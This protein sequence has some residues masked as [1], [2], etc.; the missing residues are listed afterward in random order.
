M[1][2]LSNA[3]LGEDHF[4]SKSQEFIA[5]AI[6]E[7]LENN[8]SQE[9][10]SGCQKMIGIEG[11]WGSGKSN[12]IKIVEN[13]VKK[14]HSGKFHFFTYDVWG[15]QEDLQRKA[16][17]NELVDFLLKKEILC[18]KEDEAEAD[19]WKEKVKR[20]TGTITETTQFQLPRVSWGVFFCALI[21]ITTPVCEG[22]ANLNYFENH[23]LWRLLIA[24]VP[25][26]LLFVLYFG[27][28]NKKCH[29][30]KKRPF[31]PTKKMFK[32]TFAE[33][34]CVYEDR[35]I[36]STNRE[37][38]SEINPSV[39]DFRNLLK[40]ISNALQDRNK[41]LVIIFDNMDRLP[42]EKIENLW[43]SI[44][45]FFAENNGNR[46][47]SCI[48]S[49]DRSHIREA[50]PSNNESDKSYGDGYIDKTFDIVYRVAPPVL[51]DW[52]NFFKC[53][54]LKVF[55]SIN[56]QEEYEYVVQA[57]DL[58]SDKQGFTPRSIIK[59][60]NEIALL[61]K[62]FPNIP[63]RYKAIFTLKK[64]FLIENFPDKSCLK[65]L[66]PLY[67][68]D[69][70]CDKNIAA[71]IYQVPPENVLSAV[72]VTTLKKALDQEDKEELN[73]ISNASFFKDIL[74]EAL[75][76]V[77]DLGQAIISLDSL[78]Q[79]ALDE[80]GT[81]RLWRDLYNR[82][83]EPEIV[84][85]ST[86][87]LFGVMKK[88]QEILL[89]HVDE[90][91]RLQLITKLLAPFRNTGFK[92]ERYSPNTYVELIK[93]FSEYIPLEKIVKKLQP[94]KIEPN[95]YID[96]IK[97]HGEILKS[98]PFLCGELEAHLNSLNFAQLLD[99]DCL[100]YLP[101]D[102][103]NHLNVEPLL[104]NL[105]VQNAI[106]NEPNFL[107]LLKLFKAFSKC[108]MNPKVIKWDALGL[109]FNSTQLSD[110][111]GTLLAIR[112]IFC[113]HPLSGNNPFDAALKNPSN[114]VKESM[115][116]YLEMSLS[117]EQ[118]L[119]NDDMLSTY[120]VI[121]D[122]VKEHFVLGDYEITGN[123]LFN[124][125][126]RISR[127]NQILATDLTPLY[128]KMLEFYE[129][130][131]DVFQ[132]IFDSQK[133][134]LEKVE[135]ILPKG[136]LEFV[137]QHPSDFSREL[138]QWLVAYFDSLSK[139]IWLE[140]VANHGQYGVKEALIIKYDWSHNA[141]EAI[142]TYLMDVAKEIRLIPNKAEENDVVESLDKG[143]KEHLFKNIRDEF[144]NG[145]AKMNLN[146][147]LF[148]GDWLLKYGCI[149]QFTGDV[150]RTIIPSFLLENDSAAQIIVNHFDLVKERFDKEI[151]S[152]DWLEKAKE[153]ANSR[154]NYP[155]REVLK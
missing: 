94:L 42:K 96:T 146:L 116:A 93:K 87:R 14:R 44:H 81:K 137:A 17:L 57:Y 16:I 91:S 140:R 110:L 129:S 82:A 95:A 24:S 72:Y 100:K 65:K 102:I 51:S 61:K 141:K 63:D 69:E 152:K 29:K 131:K 55:D 6:V 64:D 136:T 138:I 78:R 135:V 75:N 62:I 4:D 101:N 153:I 70:T 50:F 7:E 92:W 108:K 38:V 124:I 67:D 84:E 74:D 34:L 128:S 12:L 125:L 41:H 36:E 106:Y 20:T 109:L 154:E 115:F 23:L 54:W 113:S 47:I 11:S 5:N 33:I 97:K 28:L 27:W 151:E 143:F 48:I 130:K 149:Q 79:D 98:I 107:R 118:I 123:G 150:L 155:L 132:R 31:V 111:K 112:L 144:G 148:L 2:L 77:N 3:P 10:R 99:L 103:K 147:F 71:L 139:D 59:F 8:A 56:D 126:P 89:K 86:T 58:L 45:T 9:H 120:G 68:N 40:D 32:E 117:V 76:S 66:K 19:E 121:Q 127:I 37:F 134:T 49:F 88:S 83:Q 21:L 119:V 26:I 39:V 104:N 25:L 142:E 145:R 1:K 18:K 133:T 114:D 35:K 105:F 80:I 122:R 43:S 13:E 30:E 15:H 90:N 73:R 53:K 46:S 60:I 22:I 52:K 85:I